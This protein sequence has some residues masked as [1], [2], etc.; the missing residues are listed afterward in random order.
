[1]DI[2]IADSYRMIRSSFDSLDQF[3]DRVKRQD[4]FREC[5]DLVESVIGENGGG[6]WVANC[7]ASPL[8]VH[9]FHYSRRQKIQQSSFILFPNDIK[10][11]S[12]RC[13]YFQE[14]ISPL[15][16]DNDVI[17]ARIIIPV[18]RKR[19]ILSELALAGISKTTLFSDSIDIVCS[20]AEKNRKDAY[21][22]IIV[23]LQAESS[24]YFRSRRVA[25]VRFIFLKHN[26]GVLDA[27]S[28]NAN[29]FSGSP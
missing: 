18:K 5:L 14:N 20:E 8:F 6:S 2:A 17:V 22:L 21:S 27:A 29:A 7:C 13:G 9:S 28:G 15:P 16:K 24:V 23:F 1:M 11:D 12:P 19:T 4:Y 26:S 25:L 3:F 10:A